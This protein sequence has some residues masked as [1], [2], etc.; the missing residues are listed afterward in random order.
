[1]PEVT[2]P[3][4]PGLGPIS[5][6]RGSGLLLL[7]GATRSCRAGPERGSGWAGSP[8]AAAGN[9][10]PQPVT[11]AGPGEPGTA[12]DGGLSPTAGL[13]FTV[14]M[15]R[16]LCANAEPTCPACAAESSHGGNCRAGAAGHRVCPGCRPA[17]IRASRGQQVCRERD[18][19]NAVGMKNAI[20][21]AAQGGGRKVVGTP[22][23]LVPA[24]RRFITSREDWQRPGIPGWGG[25]LWTPAGWSTGHA[26][27]PS[28][29]SSPPSIPVYVDITATQVLSHLKLQF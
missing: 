24:R 2:Q 23:T 16:L 10:F 6:L 11:Q 9:G 18:P 7:L 28:L 4:P 15:Q 8:P 14:L 19:A 12:L 3:P 1:M 25:A 20:R 26:G 5:A 21:R 13:A 17:R 22:R 27:K 29:P